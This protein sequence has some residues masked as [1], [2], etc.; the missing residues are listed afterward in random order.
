MEGR[1]WKPSGE[2]PT[3]PEISFRDDR[4]DAVFLLILAKEQFALIRGQ[5]GKGGHGDSFAAM[6]RR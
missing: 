5:G 6:A 3:D 4:I 2:Q 1:V